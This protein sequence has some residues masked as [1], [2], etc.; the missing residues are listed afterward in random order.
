[1]TAA[2]VDDV[3]ERVEHRWLDPADEVLICA[4]LMDLGIEPK[5]TPIHAEIEYDPVHDEW[6][7]EQFWPGPEGNGEVRPDGTVRTFIRRVRRKGTALPWPTWA[8]KFDEL[9]DRVTDPDP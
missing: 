7:I 3:D 4:W 1:M 2:V 9:W 8:E 5:R 6:R